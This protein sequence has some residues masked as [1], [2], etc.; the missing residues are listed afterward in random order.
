MTRN[1]QNS[2]E[3]LVHISAPCKASDDKRFRAQAKSILK[4]LEEN[5]VASSLQVYDSQELFA[6]LTTKE[7]SIHDTAVEPDSFES[8]F[9]KPDPPSSL[10]AANSLPSS[11]ISSASSGSGIQKVQI[12]QT[13]H[14]PPGQYTP[15]HP[16]TAVTA[17]KGDFSAVKETPLVAVARTPYTV[18]PGLQGLQSTTK[19]MVLGT[20]HDK[21]PCFSSPRTP[22]STVPESESPHSRSPNFSR[23]RKVFAQSSPAEDLIE[24]SFV[25]HKRIRLEDALPQWPSQRDPSPSLRRRSPLRTVHSD[26]NSP[27]K[28]H[29]SPYKQS[30]G[31]EILTFDQKDGKKGSQSTHLPLGSAD[32]PAQRP[33]DVNTSPA[34]VS[35]TAEQLPP[36]ESVAAKISLPHLSWNIIAPPPETAAAEHGTH[37][38]KLLNNTSVNSKIIG[39][40]QPVEVT[41]DIRPFERGYWRFPI[42]TNWTEEA[43]IKFHKYV[44][45]LITEG[46]AGWGT[47]LEP[48]AMEDVDYDQAKDLESHRLEISESPMVVRSSTDKRIEVP[49]EQPRK[50]PELRFWCWGEVVRE[51]WLAIFLGAY[52]Y[53]EDLG[54]AW[55]DS[56]GQVV[57]RMQQGA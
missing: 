44:E 47:W 37:K 45:Q 3:I 24:D 55:V 35:D 56:T 7:T 19:M 31:H 40:Y 23:K 52:R 6:S 46:R 14:P 27:A 33:S 25:G 43:R 9:K 36:A 11:T 39:K 8:V 10:T 20:D 30:R 51:V 17:L 2:V 4:F 26:V 54:M 16:Q 34:K 41:R 48:I 15:S 32:R 49:R 50:K 12:A 18:N 5:R 1:Y 28:R 42:P 57:V 53:I 38:V 13:P 21:T 22:P 29:I